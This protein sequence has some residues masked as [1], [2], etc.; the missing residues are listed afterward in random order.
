MYDGFELIVT[1]LP[2]RFNTRAFTE[3]DVRPDVLMDLILSGDSRSDTHI[4]YGSYGD[5]V[6]I[7]EILDFYYTVMSHVYEDANGIGEAQ[8]QLITIVELDNYMDG[9]ELAGF[10]II[11]NLHNIVNGD[12]IAFV[13]VYTKVY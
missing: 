5:A 12:Y 10:S 1:G 8:Y 2:I 4:I 3:R 7:S 9:E 11:T 13:D 6:D